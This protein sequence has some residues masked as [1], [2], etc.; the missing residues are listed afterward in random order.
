MAQKTIANETLEEFEERINRLS[1]KE[2]SEIGKTK[3]SFLTMANNC[4]KIKDSISYDELKLLFYLR[5]GRRGE[6]SR[7]LKDAEQ[8]YD[9]Y[10]LFLNLFP[11]G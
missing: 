4:R 8:S 9:A 5:N 1:P 6:F 2:L 10:Y 7:F 3:E 11:R